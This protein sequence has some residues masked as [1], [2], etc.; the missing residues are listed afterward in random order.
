[1]PFEFNIIMFLDS[2]IK[3]NLTYLY[4]KRN[5]L[6]LKYDAICIIYLL[7]MILYNLCIYVLV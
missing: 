5:I 4:L 2:I 1:M 7:Y 3:Q 6:V